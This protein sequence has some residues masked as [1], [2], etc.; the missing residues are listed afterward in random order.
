MRDSMSN[1]LTIA[2]NYFISN[3]IHDVCS[4]DTSTDRI[5]ETDLDLF[6][7]VNDT[8]SDAT[9]GPTI[10]TGNNHVL[11]NVGQLSRQVTRVRR[12]ESRIRQPLTSTVSRAEILKNGEPF[13]KV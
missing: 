7:A 13:T 5:C 11:A 6:T 12:L 1:K 4:T 2:N 3:W 8:A 10:F 9:S